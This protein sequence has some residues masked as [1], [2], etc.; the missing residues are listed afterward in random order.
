ME[1]RTA[2]RPR[3]AQAPDGIRDVS[4][5]AAALLRA[6]A[7][8]AAS[9]HHRAPSAPAAIFNRRRPGFLARWGTVLLI[10]GSVAT[11]AVLHSAVQRSGWLAP[12]HPAVTAR[13]TAQRIAGPITLDGPRGQVTLPMSTPVVVNVWLEGCA[14]CQAA[15][16]AWRG[17][18]QQGGLDLAGLPVVNVAFGGA[19][20]AWAMDNGLDDRLVLDPS[21]GAL[22]RPLGISSFTTFIIDADGWVRLRDRPDNTG[23]AHRVAGAAKALA[24]GPPQA[25]APSP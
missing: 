18:V 21:G 2:E 14:D 12:K 11:G 16:D 22:V 17:L 13:T 19:R 9:A 8:P 5:E 20:L 23:F 25:P 1:T 10:A 24:S 3:T 4:P 7:E 6:D 15:V